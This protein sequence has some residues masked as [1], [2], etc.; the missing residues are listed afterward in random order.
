MATGMRANLGLIAGLPDNTVRPLL[1][2]LVL[3]EASARI[4]VKQC[5]GI[6]RVIAATAPLDPQVAGT[7]SGSLIGLAA[8]E[9]QPVCPATPL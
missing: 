4:Q 8:P 5:A 7:L 1:D 3:Q 6:E 2:A 9:T